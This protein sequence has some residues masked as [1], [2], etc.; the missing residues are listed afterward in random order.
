MCGGQMTVSGVTLRTFVYL[1]WDRNSE[2]VQE[3]I[4]VNCPGWLAS[5]AQVSTYL[6]IANNV[7]L[8]PE[9]LQGL[10][11]LTLCLQSKHYTY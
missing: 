7:F 5:T 6:C 8:C 2:F 1:L 4:R 9:V 3:L 10:W 11:E